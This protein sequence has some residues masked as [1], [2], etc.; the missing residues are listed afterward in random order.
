MNIIIQLLSILISFI[1]GMLLK[2]LN[3]IK[4]IIVNSENKILESII[5]IVY[6]YILVIIYIILLFKVNYGVFHIYF[7]IFIIL[8]YI[9]MSK[10]VK[11][12]KKI[13][14]KHVF[15]KK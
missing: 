6:V 14:I 5:N 13:L 10:T 4:K 9:V 1:Y 3:T 15:I 7:S 8:G 12:T 2:I 11:F